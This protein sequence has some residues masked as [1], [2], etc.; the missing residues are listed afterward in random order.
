MEKFPTKN[1]IL[2]NQKSLLKERL[3]Y[4]AVGDIK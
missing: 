4:H 2:I 1:V 3:Q